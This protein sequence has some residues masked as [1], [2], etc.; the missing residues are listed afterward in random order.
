MDS[1]KMAHCI[2]NTPSRAKLREHF[3]AWRQN[4]TDEQL[5]ADVELLKSDQFDLIYRKDPLRGRRLARGLRLL[6]RDTQILHILALGVLATADCARAAARSRVAARL[7]L[8]AA[9]LFS[10]ASAPVGW[11][12][13][14]GGWLNAASEAGEAI[15]EADLAQMDRACEI[16]RA[17]GDPYRLANVQQI[18]A[19]VLRDHNRFAEALRRWDDAL[20]TLA[21]LDT[22]RA[23][24]SRALIW[25]NQ[26]RTRLWMGDRDEA[27]ALYMRAQ[28]EFIA[29][30][31][32]ADALTQLNLSIVEHERGHPQEA[33]RLVAAATAGFAADEQRGARAFARIYHTR[34]L[35]QLNR[36]EE[37][38]RIS[39]Q[40]LEDLD[41]HEDLHD[42]LD[43]LIVRAEA[44]ARS[45]DWTGA[46][47]CLERA[48]A[49]ASGQDH[50]HTIRLR[51]LRARFLLRD[52]P[53]RARTLALEVARESRERDLLLHE[54]M[55]SL[56][57][58]EAAY[59]VGAYDEAAQT[60][61]ALFA[62]STAP[63]LEIH[64][65]SELLL[66]RLARQRADL[67]EAIVHYDAMA[68]A[69]GAFV[70]ELAYDRSA[71]FLQDKDELYL[72]AL[73]VALDADQ[74]VKALS[75]LER[76]R[77]RSAW[78]ASSG[79]DVILDSLRARHQNLSADLLSM[80][81]QGAAEA[82]RELHSLARE[83]AERLAAAAQRVQASEAID[84][85]AII[86]ALPPDTTLV[87]FAV[88]SQELIVFALTS[89][90]IAVER[91]GREKLRAVKDHIRYLAQRRE[92]Y[93]A[94]AP[95]ASSAHQDEAAN[96]E[97]RTN[98]EGIQ[99]DL[100]ALWNLLL[101]P[102]VLHL[103]PAG[104]TVMLVPHDRL[105]AL[106][107]AALFDGARYLAERWTVACLTSCQALLQLRK[108]TETDTRLRSS[109]A[110]QLQSLLALGYAAQERDLAH[111][112]V[113]AER[114][115][116][117]MGGTSLIG[118]K[119]T[120]AALRAHAATCAYLHIAAHGALRLDT[121]QSSFIQLADSLFHPLDA[122][123][124]PLSQCR[125]V[126]LSACETGLGGGQRDGRPL[127]GDERIG[128]VR[129]FGL[130]G[131]GAVV[132]TLWRV[133][134]AASR[135]FMELVYERIVAGATTARALAAAQQAFI[136]GMAGES[137]RH[138]YYWAG[139]QLVTFHD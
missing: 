7:F 102:I 44:L 20:A 134:D 11:A 133:D 37:A 98:R 86:A 85:A 58:A 33:L 66:A 99:S 77:A 132:A 16:L 126:T 76:L 123:T 91:L 118:S 135:V 137:Q 105:H 116:A 120:G 15:T 71:D 114:V 68:T 73:T 31:G 106:P 80:S 10:Q 17:A 51:L 56:I 84:V 129:A 52:D 38:E 47:N 62:R 103:P 121:P 63:G 79:G 87:A 83:I 81:G 115:A 107:L 24:Y 95:Q 35:L 101:K 72:E 119:A 6:G 89:K 28:A 93:A 117:L 75:F 8:H 60:I 100:H 110:A 65:R 21:A 43:G 104:G 92:S 54:E 136:S 139:F 88:T 59:A 25:G 125:L 41:A 29:L 94:R 53:A 14:Q 2:W 45:G 48:E 27:Y 3:A 57:A 113:E 90:K 112:T 46:A 70:G 30:D 82:R 19:L 111:V 22:P 42:L 61:H 1:G 78:L 32:D 122:Q 12:R 67:D 124:L 128:L 39:A 130:A 50:P 109:N 108:V 18:I 96:Q 64:Y 138:P 97:E 5:I 23:R 36:V 4:C 40:T 9:D 55:A 127:G 34:M 26:A 74:Q 69:L 13:A 49:L 131:A